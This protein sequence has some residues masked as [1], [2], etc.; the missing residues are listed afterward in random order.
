MIRLKFCYLKQF[1][2]FIKSDEFDRCVSL[3]FVQIRQTK[4]RR[5]E[6]IHLE[7][8]CSLEILSRIRAS[9]GSIYSLFSASIYP[10]HFSKYSL[11]PE[12]RNTCTPDIRFTIYYQRAM[13]IYSNLKRNKWNLFEFENLGSESKWVK[14]V[15]LVEVIEV[16]MHHGKIKVATFGSFYY[17]FISTYLFWFWSRI[18]SELAT[19]HTLREIWRLEEQLLIQL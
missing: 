13:E 9:G 3:L 7:N 11:S 5:S 1:K 18:Y 10:G 12:Q 8:C 16:M 19:I 14:W 2:S 17:K 15:N 4:H 6:E